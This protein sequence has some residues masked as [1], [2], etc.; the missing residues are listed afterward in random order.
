M[1]LTNVL[2]DARSSFVMISFAAAVTVCLGLYG[3]WKKHCAEKKTAG[4]WKH[5]LVTVLSL[6]L[7]FAV[8]IVGMMIGQ[9]ALAKGFVAARDRGALLVSTAQAEGENDGE[10]TGKTGL[11]GNQEDQGISADIAIRETDLGDLKDLNAVLSGRVDIWKKALEYYTEH[12]GDL[13]FG[14]SVD[15]AVNEALQID[16]HCHNMLVQTLMEGGLVGLGLL[17]GLIGYFLYHTAQLWRRWKLPLWQRALPIPALAILLMEMAECLTHFSY[18]HVPM[19][20]L[21]FFIGCSVAMSL[22]LKKNEAEEA[23]HT[24]EDMD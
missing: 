9:R 14:L 11:T 21:Y 18:G 1:I 22:G 23:V 3:A 13:P 24:L 6:A 7:C 8:S 15:G 4:G 20:I 17:L 5:S 10:A 12:P 2:T 16:A 19:T